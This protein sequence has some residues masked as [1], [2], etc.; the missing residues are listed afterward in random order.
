MR[1]SRCN[2]GL[3]PFLPYDFINSVSPLKLYEYLAA[4]LPVVSSP[5]PDCL[6]LRS[7]GIVWVAQTPEEFTGCLAQALRVS[8]NAD[9]KKARQELAGKNTWEC[10]WQQIEDL[11]YGNHPT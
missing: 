4:G 3:I 7:P 10:R 9:L 6:R 2:V 5:L 11:I 1:V 8:E